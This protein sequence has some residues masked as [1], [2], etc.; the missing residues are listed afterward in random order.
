MRELSGFPEFLIIFIAVAIP[1]SARYLNSALRKPDDPRGRGRWCL[2]QDYQ[3][4][5][6]EQDYAAPTSKASRRN[7][8]IF[9]ILSILS[10]ILTRLDHGASP[11][12][13]AEGVSSSVSGIVTRGITRIPQTRPA[14]MQRIAA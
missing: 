2:R 3:D 11:F 13:F 6:D 10:A 7:P 1:C 4:F 8:V 5:Q 9:Q 14:P 12:R